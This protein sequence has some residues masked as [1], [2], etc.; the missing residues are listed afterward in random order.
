VLFDASSFKIGCGFE[1]LVQLK[2][3]NSKKN[4]KTSK[5]KI[6]IVETNPLHQLPRI[7]IPWRYF[8]D[9]PEMVLIG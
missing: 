3:R 6:H 1:A 5:Q 7:F 8:V 2:K 4:E 9:E